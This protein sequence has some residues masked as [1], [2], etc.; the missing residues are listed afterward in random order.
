MTSLNRNKRSVKIARHSSSLLIG[1]LAS[2]SV[3]ACWEEIGV[4]Y[5]VNPY[6]L[7]AIAKQES[8]FNAN[9]V[10]K[11]SNGTRDIGVMQINSIWLPKLAPYGITEQ[12]L[13]EPCV[14]IAVGAWILR[15]Q[16]LKFGNTWEAV[17]AYHSKTPTHK[18]KYAGQVN[19]RLWKL[20]PPQ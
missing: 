11:N 19:D 14:N 3:H 10:R 20:L 9:A 12:H 16:Q 13:Y 7:G 8:N 1:V 4:R 5:G 15:Q 6:L 17:G 18:W 2:F